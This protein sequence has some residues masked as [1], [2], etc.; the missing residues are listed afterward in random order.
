MQVRAI[1]A[2]AAAVV[3]A[4]CGGGAPSVEP[5]PITPTTTTATAPE[6]VGGSSASC[7]ADDLEVTDSLASA[8]NNDGHALVVATVEAVEPAFELDPDDRFAPIYTPLRLTGTQVLAGERA[9]G[10][11][12]FALGGMVGR[13]AYESSNAAPVVA[14]GSRVLLELYTGGTGERAPDGPEVF[15][16]YPVLADG[17]VVVTGGCL[18]VTD[19]TPSGTR[20]EVSYEVVDIEGVVQTV[21]GERGL[22]PLAEVES[23]LAGG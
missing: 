13:V 11:V 12:V 18:R 8:A 23:A 22:V 19:D 15:T 17:R 4:G 6:I 16:A 3:L 2:V 20:E 21:R 9:T 1:M 5:P 10:D 14:P 7:A